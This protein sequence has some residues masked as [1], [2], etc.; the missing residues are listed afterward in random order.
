MD[1]RTLNLGIVALG[2]AAVVPRL[3]SAAEPDLDA[4]L[5]PRIEGSPDAKLTMIEYS[6]LT[7]P[8]CATFHTEI[9]PKIREVYIDTGKLRL[10]M[11]DFPL[12]Q[13]ALRAAAMARCAPENRYFPLMDMLFKQQ[14][15]W[16]RA[17]DPIA[18]IK[19]IGR[20]AGISGETADA[21]MSSEPLLDGILKIRLGGQQDH[22]VGSTPTFIVGKEKIVGAQPFETFAKAI[23]DQLG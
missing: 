12:D 22:D 16:S 14:S 13:Y 2:A 6:S 5:A 19:Q 10:E 7:C 15:K 18:A 17:T 8:H 9:L 4:A 20:L 23:D 21:C 11:R 1:R 3:A